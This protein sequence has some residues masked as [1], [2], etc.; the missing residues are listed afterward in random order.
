MSIL[1]PTATAAAAAC[2]RSSW[3][4]VHASVDGAR[5]LGNVATPRGRGC[6]SPVRMR[7]Q[8]QALAFNEAAP[9]AAARTHRAK[10]SFQSGKPE[11]QPCND[12]DSTSR[13]V[14]LLPT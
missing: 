4:G 11:A 12:K 1:M 3:T 5:R 14:H 13:C 9:A 8:L 6:R 2:A 10:F 7:T